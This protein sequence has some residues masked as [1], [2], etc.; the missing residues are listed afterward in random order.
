MSVRRESLTPDDFAEIADSLRRLADAMS[1]CQ[2]MM[3]RVKLE[4]VDVLASFVST[5]MIGILGEK[6]EKVRSDVKAICYLRERRLLERKDFSDLAP[7][8][9]PRK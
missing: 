9:K 8:R 6:V 5:G 4:K 7:K 3:N 1:D 2:A